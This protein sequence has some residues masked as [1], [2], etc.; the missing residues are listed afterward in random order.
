MSKETW[1]RSWRTGIS[2]IKRIKRDQSNRLSRRGLFRFFVWNFEICKVGLLL[3]SFV[4]LQAVM[5]KKISTGCCREYYPEGSEYVGVVV[6]EFTSLVMIMIDIEDK[7]VRHTD[8]WM[9]MIMGEVPHRPIRCW[10]AHGC[11]LSESRKA[12]H[13]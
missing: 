3:L 6:D 12:T 1:G 4:L 11:L 10:D 2:Q 7:D 8:H 5:I 13:L 9:I